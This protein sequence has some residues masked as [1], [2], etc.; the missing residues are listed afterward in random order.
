MFDFIPVYS[1]R[2]APEHP[3]PAAFDDC[4]KVTEYLLKNGAKFSIDKHRI[5][6]AGKHYIVIPQCLLHIEVNNE[7]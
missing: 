1:Y 6:V 4:Q 5:G 2:L 7:P 3:F